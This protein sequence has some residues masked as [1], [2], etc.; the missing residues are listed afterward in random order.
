[1]DDAAMDRGQHGYGL[2]PF[3][4]WLS[5]HLP[6]VVPD[7]AVQRQFGRY[8]RWADR[9]SVRRALAVLTVLVFAVVLWGWAYVESDDPLSVH[10][11]PHRLAI[12]VTAMTWMFNMGMMLF[13]SKWMMAMA[14]SS[15][16]E[17]SVLEYGTSYD[18]LTPQ[19]RR[20]MLLRYRAELFSQPFHPDEWQA[21]QHERAER[22]AFRLLRRSA[23]VVTVAGWA[24]YLMAPKVALG[25]WLRWRGLLVDSPLVLLWM[26]TALFLL[27]TLVRM[28]TLPDEVGE[29]RVIEREV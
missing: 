18:K 14:G 21:A 1:M 11:L 15:V 17:R 13:F 3:A 9:Q 29:P 12:F 28:W 7:P 23:V 22:T 2:H 24:V 8:N 5:D 4:Q 27:P 26:T 10:R 16:E 6:I 19:E 20:E 25:W